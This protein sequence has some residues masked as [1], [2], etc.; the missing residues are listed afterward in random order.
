MYILHKTSTNGNTLVKNP[1]LFTFINIQLVVLDG[2]SS[3]FENKVPVIS[4]FNSD[5]KLKGEV[6]FENNELL[7]SQGILY[8]AT[9]SHLIFSENVKVEFINNTVMLND[10]AF[11]KAFS[12]TSSTLNTICAFQFEAIDNITDALNITFKNSSFPVRKLL[13]KL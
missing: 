6:R 4:A 9:L 7:L 10:N 3:F 12:T 5:V 8:L 13:V 1:S 11:I 2:I